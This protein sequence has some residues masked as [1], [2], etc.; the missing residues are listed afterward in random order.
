MSSQQHF[1]WQQAIYE[2]DKARGDLQFQTER[3]ADEEV[4][5]HCNELR[6]QVDVVRE[7][8]IQNVW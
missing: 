8:A 6:R 7:T 4:R 5:D 2:W 3:N 1:R